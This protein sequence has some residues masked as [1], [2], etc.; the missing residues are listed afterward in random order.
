[1][2]TFQTTDGDRAFLRSQ[3]ERLTERLPAG[4]VESDRIYTLVSAHYSAEGRFYHNLRHVASLL[5][6]LADFEH[7]VG[8]YDAVRFAAW[9]HDVVYD[10]R[11]DDNEE[12]SAE[13]A[14]RALREL[15]APAETAGRVV[16][17]ILAT[18][19]HS[20]GGLSRDGL[21]FLDA[22]LSILGAP[23][24]TYA[25]YGRAIREEYSWVPD[26]LYRRGRGDVLRGFLGRSRL[27]YTDE[28][29]GRLE[30]RARVNMSLEVETLSSSV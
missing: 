20:A 27:Y 28:M 1:M 14:A 16:E 6:L 12:S 23:A 4:R 8:D 7:G 15:G 30:G 29:F 9:F 3:W 24:D 19:G 5:R 26:S 10:T 17:M 18:K 25:R 11:R 13:F 21:L 2:D 22:D